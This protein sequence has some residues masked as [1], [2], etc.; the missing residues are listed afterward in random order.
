MTQTAARTDQAISTHPEVAQ[1][2]GSMITS[3]AAKALAV[4]RISTGFVFLWAFLDK[5]FGLNYATPSAKAWINGGSPTKGF[6]ASVEVGPFQS[7]F[8][9]IAGTWWANGLFMLGLLT[10]G[11]ALIAGVALRIAAAAGTTMLA[12]MWLAEFPLAQHT[13]TGAPNGSSNPLIDDHVIYA[14]VLIVLALTYAGRTWGLGNTW[15]RLP[16][17]HHHP[18]TI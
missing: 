15:A 1:L 14:I 11:L 16:F 13:S 2:G 12:M 5:T 7:L 17:V 3:T 18:W 10:V 8:H 6:L 9:A 4:L